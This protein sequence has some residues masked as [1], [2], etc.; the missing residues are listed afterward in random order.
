MSLSDIEDP[1]DYPMEL[2]GE[3]PPLELFLDYNIKSSTLREVK[4]EDFCADT[5]E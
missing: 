2:M 4:T 1:Y 5:E 3:R